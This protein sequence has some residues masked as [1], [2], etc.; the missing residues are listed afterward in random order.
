MR[1]HALVEMIQNEQLKKDI[2]NFRIGDTIRVHTR[3]IEGQKERIQVFTGTVI[4]R[5]GSGLSETFSL[6]RVA[7]GEGMERLFPLHSPRIAKI[8]VIKEGQVRRAKLYYLRGTSGKASK[9]KGR[10]GF[11]RKSAAVEKEPVAAN[12]ANES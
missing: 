7:Y 11:N 8:E 3:I 5:K 2:P 12:V 1:K 4:A 9:V 6:H 10:V